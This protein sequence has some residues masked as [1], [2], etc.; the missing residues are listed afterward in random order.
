MVRCN[1]ISSCAGDGADDKAAVGGARKGLGQ[2]VN[3]AGGGQVAVV[4][5]AIK[6]ELVGGAQDGEMV[7]KND[8]GAL[9][10]VNGYFP[11]GR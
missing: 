10:K 7:P 9:E 2:A 11:N 6:A 4:G 1:A 5:R 8:V 3:G